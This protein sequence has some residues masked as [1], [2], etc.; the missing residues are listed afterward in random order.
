MVLIYFSFYSSKNNS[1]VS[2]FI[3]VFKIWVFFLF[4][5]SILLVNFLGLFK[6]LFIGSLYFFSILCFIYFHSILYYF[7]TS[8]CF[9]VVC[10]SFPSFLREKVRQ[11]IWDLSS[12]LIHII[13]TAINFPINTTLAASHISVLKNVSCTIEKTVYSATIGW[14]IQ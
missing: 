5:W 11:L 1:D 12:L 4:A 8:S 6:D 14:S 9:L 7:F 3:I 2:S 13:F 10:S